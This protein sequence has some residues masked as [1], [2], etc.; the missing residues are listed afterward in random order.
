VE[1]ELL[2][3]TDETMQLRETVE[4]KCTLTQTLESQI[5]TSA[6]RA[7]KVEQQ[8]KEDLAEKEVREV[9]H[10][11]RV[12]RM[13]AMVRASRKDYNGIYKLLYKLFK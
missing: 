12:E 9:E 11:K 6:E 13:Q 5:Q 10:Q 2:N 7:W 1:G 4:E 3:A 8:L